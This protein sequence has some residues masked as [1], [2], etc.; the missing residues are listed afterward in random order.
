VDAV[1]AVADVTVKKERKNINMPTLMLKVKTVRYAVI[2]LNNRVRELVIADAD[3]KNAW[4][5]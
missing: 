2:R 1:V 5:Q 3:K 4:N